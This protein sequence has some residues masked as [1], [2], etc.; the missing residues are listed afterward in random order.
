MLTTHATAAPADTH[1]APEAQFRSGVTCLQNQDAACAR[2]ALNKIPSQSAYAKVLAGAIAVSEQDFD[3]AFSLLLPLHSSTTLHD[4]AAAI[5]H[6][7]LAIAYDNQADTLRAL[8]QR[9]AA[10]RFLQSDE[11]LHQHHTAIWHQLSTLPRDELVTIRGESPDTVVQGWID[12]ALAAKEQEGDALKNW[13]NFYPGHPA[14][15]GFSQELLTQRP[16]SPSGHNTTATT[17]TG[18][19]AILLPFSVDMYYP[20][21][22]AIMQGFSAAQAQAGDHRELRIYASTDDPASIN[23]L[24]QQIQAD[25]V[26]MMLG[27][28]TRD[29]ISHLSQQSPPS[30][31]VLALNQA[32]DTADQQQNIYLYGQSLETEIAQII[33]TAQRLGMQSA[34]IVAGNSPLS[35]R[36]AQLFNVMWQDAGGH[37]ITPPTPTEDENADSETSDAQ[38]Q[39]N[40]NPADM[41]FLAANSEEASRIR[42]H[43]DTATPTFSISHIYSGMAQDPDNSALNA[44]RFLDMPWLLQPDAKQFSMFKEA[45]SGLP[46]GEMQRWFALGADAYR[47]LDHLNRNPEQALTFQG[48]TG[49]IEISTDGRIHRTLA[50]G[51]F[52]TEGVILETM[53]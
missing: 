41:I 6:S 45:A 49:K 19:I 30:F 51:R 32:D 44:I 17:Q 26:D 11:Q 22:D 5:L 31:P 7:S 1:T 40:P 36:M 53:P 13:P 50:T 21:S 52:S 25:N 43:L 4:E 14:A 27:P 18:T 3:T 34:T 28:L 35:E 39:A 29:E 24:Y 38:P 48:L 37:T 15:D 9:T 20:V 8:E 33:S 12:L 47:I 42:P 10:E 2:L 23:D 16:T 46:P